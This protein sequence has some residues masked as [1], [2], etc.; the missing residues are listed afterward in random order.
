[1]ALPALAGR[2]VCVAASAAGWLAGDRTAAAR[3][4]AGG[5]V[6]VAGPGLTYSRAEAAMVAAHHP[7]AR[8][9]PARAAA[10]LAALDGAT[11]AHLATHGTFHAHSPL[12]SGLVLDDGPLPAYDLLGL[13]RPPR[14]VV[15]S[16]CE[17]GMAHTPADG[18]PLGLAGALLSRGTACVVACVVPVRDE[19]ALALMTVFHDLLAAGGTPAGALAGAASAT[20]VRGFA[21]FGAGHRAL[22]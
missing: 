19:E 1:P 21:C 3:Q 16:A 2:P 15:L 9:V 20:G 8:R 11:L 18:G 13:R 6:A 10:V 4:E 7:G 5:V 14:L 12:M 22:G 17:A